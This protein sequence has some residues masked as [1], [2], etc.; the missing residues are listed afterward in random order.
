MLNGK[1][2][3]TGFTLIELLVVISIIALLLSIL[4]P[5]LARARESARQVACAAKYRSTHSATAMYL[6][7]NRHILH[8]PSNGNM[9]FDLG[10]YSGRTGEMLPPNSPLAYWGVAY[11]PY[12]DN[13]YTVFNCASAKWAFWWDRARRP[14]EEKAYFNSDYGMNGYLV[15]DH[16][17]TQSGI[18]YTPIGVDAYKEIK[19]TRRVTDFRHHSETIVMHDHPESMLDDNG[20]MYHINPNAQYGM[21]NYPNLPSAIWQNLVQWK[22]ASMSGNDYYTGI[23]REHWRH[24]GSSNILWL[25]GHISNLRETLGQDVPYAWYTGRLSSRWQY[26]HPAWRGQFGM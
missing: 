25:D 14:S 11:L 6:E 4:M 26:P 2:K 19:Y 10:L 5:S 21:S 1:T 15:W 22:D 18:V 23:D 16:P 12:M 9:I 17:T 7:D 3:K 24:M 13:D 20:D 8:R